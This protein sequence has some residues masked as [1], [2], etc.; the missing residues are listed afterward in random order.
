[1]MYATAPLADA[2]QFMK[3][4]FVRLRSHPALNI[5]PPLPL[6]HAQFL[7]VIPAMLIVSNVDV[8]DRIDPFPLSRV[9]LSNVLDPSKVNR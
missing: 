7:N 4:V 8:S 2:L 6:L 3:E 5:T 9:M 1:M